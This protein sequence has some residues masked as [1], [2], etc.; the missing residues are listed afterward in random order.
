M[1]TCWPRPPTPRGHA[2]VDKDL[3]VWCVGKYAPPPPPPPPFPQPRKTRPTRTT[4][5][6]SLHERVITRLPRTT[7]AHTPFGTTWLP[8]GA[9]VAAAEAAT[10]HAFSSFL[11]LT[12]TPF[13]P[14][15]RS[16]LQK[17]SSLLLLSHTK[18]P[19]ACPLDE[20]NL[21]PAPPCSLLL[22]VCAGVCLSPP[23]GRRPATPP[24]EWEWCC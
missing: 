11:T 18:P 7:C 21:P 4:T 15:Q 6:F 13:P 19:P 10:A 2:R 22:C 9:C 16:L 17:P 24:W 8:R 14:Q 12:L 3:W 1:C 5:P 23:L 20:R